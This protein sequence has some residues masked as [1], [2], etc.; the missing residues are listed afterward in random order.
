[1][2]NYFDGQI[3]DILPENIAKKP[4]VQ[5]LSY[6]LQQGCRLLYKCSQKLYIYSDLDNQPEE[7]LDLMAAELRTQFYG[8]NLD[9]EKK[10]QLVRNTLTWYMTAGTPAAIEGLL[11]TVF[12]W[13]RIE[14]WFEYG[15]RPYYF[16]PVIGIEAS[17]EE[18]NIFLKYLKLIKN[19]RSWLDAMVYSGVIDHKDL[20]NITLKNILTRITIPFWG[21][22]VFDGTWI[23]DGSMV[24]KNR[25]RYGLSPAIIYNARIIT[26]IDENKKF[27]SLKH[28]F[29]TSIAEKCNA[30]IINRYGIRICGYCLVIIQKHVYKIKVTNKIDLP[31]IYNR[32]GQHIKPDIKN[33]IVVSFP[34]FSLCIK[35]VTKI[36]FQ[37]SMDQN[38]TAGNFSAETKSKDYWLFDGSVKMD[39]NRKFNSIYRKETE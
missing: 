17:Q 32:W 30:R 37:A 35:H 4:E 9:I 11:S 23:F 33:R 24:F 1:M 2:V 15:G 19:A 14:E 3:T 20:E 7:I 38:E 28:L 36:S 13:G 8:S 16:K 12:G 26:N 39:G 6:A 25:R 18:I 27:T 10:K 21:G 29:K 31:H 34:V 5:A 22:F